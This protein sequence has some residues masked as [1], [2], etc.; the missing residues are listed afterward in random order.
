MY[1][2]FRTATKHFNGVSDPRII[3]IGASAGG[4]EALR[5]L[6]GAFP[7]NFDGSLFVVLHIDNAESRLPEVL[8]AA[9]SLPAVHPSD[10]QHIEKGLIY[11]VPPD[12][13][14]LAF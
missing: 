8:S 7:E 12:H 10:G 14:L 6:V 1:A 3:V 13:H 9:G 2:V 4:V 11:V 5:R